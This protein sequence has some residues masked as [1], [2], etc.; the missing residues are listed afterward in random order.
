MT[1]T[2]TFQLW[3][4][5]ENVFKGV[6]L[7]GI[8][9]ITATIDEAVF[10]V[11]DDSGITVSGTSINGRR[12]WAGFTVTKVGLWPVKVHLT[13]SDTQ[14]PILVFYLQVVAAPF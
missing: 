8:V 9:G 3:Q 2:V 10:E 12:A 5:S 11:P 14:R 6:D 13:L 4:G 1:D 7:T